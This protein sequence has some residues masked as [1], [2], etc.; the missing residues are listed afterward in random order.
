MDVTSAQAAARQP[1]VATPLKKCGRDT[2]HSPCCSRS[3]VTQVSCESGCPLSR[4]T[5]LEPSPAPGTAAKSGWKACVWA[6][7][8]C[9]F[10]HKDA[11]VCYTSCC[12]V[13]GGGM[14]WQVAAAGEKRVR[15]AHRSLT[16]LRDCGTFCGAHDSWLI[17]QAKGPAA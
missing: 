4:P 8:M 10:T 9:V 1:T 13:C 7:A 11:T 2:P 12:R 14:T 3:T 17:W 5:T 15:L 16:L 6:A